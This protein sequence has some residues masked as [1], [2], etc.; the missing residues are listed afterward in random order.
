M[1]WNYRILKIGAE[2]GMHEVFYDKAANPISYTLEKVS[3]RGDS[4]D[5]FRLDFSRYQ[6]ALNKPVLMVSDNDKIVEFSQGIGK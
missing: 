1:T 3:P 6:D 5:A 4:L 2:F